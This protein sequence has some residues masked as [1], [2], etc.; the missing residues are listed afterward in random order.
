M[1]SKF[2][3]LAGQVIVV[4]G[5]ASGVGLEA[6]KLAAK[7]GAAVVLA[8]REEHSLR[9][10]CEEIGRAGGRCHPVAGDTATSEGCDRVARAAAARFGRID[11]WIEA[12]GEAA[13]VAYAAR[14]LALHIGDRDEPGA[15]VGFGRRF[16]AAARAQLRAAKGKVAA[17][18]VKLPRDWRHDSPPKVA[19]EAALHAVTRPMGRMAVAAKGARLTASTTARKHPGVLA[20]VGLLALAGAALWFGRGRIAQAATAARPR[21][22]RVVRPVLTEVVKRRP[23]MAAKMVAKHPKQALQLARALR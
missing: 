20:G 21:M 7:A 2:K 12:A 18:L 17:T 4:T 9:A 15:L 6:A 3:P 8:G 22:A 13:A 5:A 11:S 10:V 16:D 19:A 1:A 14:V 23:M